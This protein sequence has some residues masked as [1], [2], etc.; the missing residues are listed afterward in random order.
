M[1]HRLNALAEIGLAL[2]GTFSVVLG[3]EFSS[4]TQIFLGL[5]VVIQ[6]VI[7]KGW[8]YAAREWEALYRQE[9][10]SRRVAAGVVIPPGDGGL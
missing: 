3:I 7:M 6:A 9:I 1:R 2:A 4:L 10:R 8:R 5:S